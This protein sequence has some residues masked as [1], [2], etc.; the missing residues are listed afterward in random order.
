G[1]EVAPGEVLG[2]KSDRM[3]RG[4]RFH[5]DKGVWLNH[6]GE[7]VEALRGA[8]VMVD[9]RERRDTVRREIAAAAREAGG[10]A[11]VRE[12]LIDE[13]NCLVEWPKAILCGF[14]EEFLRV[15]QEALISTME[16]NQKF[17][18]VLDRDG[19]LTSRF[20]GIANL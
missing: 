6:A 4:H 7:Y 13:V 2:L 15:P 1:R 20:V 3:S 9:P 18:P 5:H 16:G 8:F 17:F 12:E 11:R 10:E 19:R 14:D